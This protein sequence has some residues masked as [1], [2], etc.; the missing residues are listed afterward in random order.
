[1]EDCSA[2]AVTLS[3]AQEVKT[4][5]LTASA[6]D[7]QLQLEKRKV[8]SQALVK[9]YT[10]QV[11]RYDDYLRAVINLA[12]LELLLERA[13]M[14]DEEREQGNIRSPLHGIPIMIKDNIATAPG[15][16]LDTTAGSFALVNSRPRENAPIVERVRRPSL[17]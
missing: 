8:S 1:M 3:S 2:S 15:T 12:P 14:L 7:L 16:G 4:D 11:V 6:E 10:S 17:T 9:L 13:K 5:L